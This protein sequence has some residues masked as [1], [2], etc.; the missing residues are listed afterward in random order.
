MPRR[1]QVL[2]FCTAHVAVMSSVT[3]CAHGPLC[4][5]MGSCRREHLTIGCRMQC[6]HTIW[7]SW[8]AGA[9]QELTDAKRSWQPQLRRWR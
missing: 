6:E 4:R 9:A 1:R 8:R 2:G 3:L 5:A 7:C